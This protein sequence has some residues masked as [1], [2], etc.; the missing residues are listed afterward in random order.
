MINKI[1]TRGTFCFVFKF[2]IKLEIYISYIT[3]YCLLIFNTPITTGTAIN[4]EAIASNRPFE[5]ATPNNVAPTTFGEML[6]AFA[7]SSKYRI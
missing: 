5:V 1:L 7:Y 3:F 2:Y 6:I 4:A